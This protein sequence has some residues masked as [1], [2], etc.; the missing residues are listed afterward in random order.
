[1]K[2]KLILGIH[3]S[4]TANTHDPSICLIDNGKIIF[5][6]EEERFNRN[7]TSLGLLPYNAINCLLKDQNISIKDIDLVVST[8]TTNI[9][10]K[11]KIINFFNSYFGYCPKVLIVNH[12]MSH[13]YGAFLSSGFEKSL[14]IS[15]DGIGDKI[16]TLVA[17]GGGG[18]VEN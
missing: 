5:A 11:K 10:I 2:R 12:A 18:G 8:G 14:V 3:A 15:I 6:A 17:N 9:Y 1:M 4:F 16:S 7:K 13:A